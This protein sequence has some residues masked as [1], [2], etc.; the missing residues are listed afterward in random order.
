MSDKL[1]AAAQAV[2]DAKDI[3]FIREMSV[4]DKVYLRLEDAINALKAAL[5]EPAIKESL[6][7]AEPVAWLQ[8]TRYGNRLLSFNE[9]PKTE[10]P[11]YCG[12]LTPD[13]KNYPL[14]LEPQ[15]EWV[16]LTGDE[17]EDINKDQTL[18]GIIR[19][20]EAKLREKN[21]G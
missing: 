5:A 10:P 20:A 11:S 6:T 9:P 1:R 14:Y 19:T 2:G 4:H 7:V 12:K 21:G 17:I 8:I 16:G 13:P 18:W 15:K 3:L